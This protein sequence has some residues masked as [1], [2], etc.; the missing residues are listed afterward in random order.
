M[1]RQKKK[2]TMIGM[3]QVFQQSKLLRSWMLHGELK[4][5]PTPTA[6]SKPP[7]AKNFPHGEKLMQ[8][9]GD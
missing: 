1:R 5:D 8:Y 9:S 7:D 2:K 3:N 4:K 6:L